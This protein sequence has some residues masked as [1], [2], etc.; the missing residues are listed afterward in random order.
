M[1]DSNPLPYVLTAAKLDATG[2][3]WLATLAAYEFEILYRPGKSNADAD[4]MSRIPIDIDKDSV[5][6]ICNSTQPLLVDAVA[7]TSDVVDIAG[8]DMY[9]DVSK[10]INWEV[11]Q[12]SDPEL[13]LSIKL[14]KSGQR[15]KK[16]QVPSSPIQRQYEHLKL[17]NN[18][19][20]RKITVD[21]KERCQLVLPTKHIP[22]VLGLLHDK[23][24]HPVEIEP[25]VLS[26][27]DSTGQE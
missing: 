14:I 24:G 5:R 10:D 6:T 21:G 27:I 17:I 15:P 25:L 19:F 20:R 1:T 11:A 9:T 3:R 13:Q 23:M 2:H 7:I 18:I 26:G 4:A 12:A 8:I 16:G 22:A